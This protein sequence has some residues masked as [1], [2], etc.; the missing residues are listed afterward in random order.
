[1]KKENMLI[2][3][4]FSWT[5]SHFTYSPS[6]PFSVARHPSTP[7]PHLRGPS[8]TDPPEA[9]PFPMTQS[10]QCTLIPTHQ[11]FSKRCCWC[12]YIPILSLLVPLRLPG[13]TMAAGAGGRETILLRPLDSWVPDIHLP[14]SHHM[15]A[16]EQ[17]SVE[18]IL[19]TGPT[20][21]P[22][23][24]T[25]VNP[26]HMPAC[27]QMFQASALPVSLLHPDRER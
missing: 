11:N 18:Y 25:E 13:R 4:N 20:E 2:F 1:M 5:S 14:R 22:P 12:C 6:I 27:S 24:I 19:C 17:W 10:R 26:P 8:F 16:V 9:Q 15:S 3:W 23:Q 7:R 21:H